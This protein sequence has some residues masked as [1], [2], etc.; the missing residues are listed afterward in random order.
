MR[1]E[2]RDNSS[3]VNLWTVSLS[4][5]NLPWVYRDSVSKIQGEGR[6]VIWDIFFPI[7]DT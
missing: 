5:I 2:V 3:R 7:F 4:C 6:K 1:P